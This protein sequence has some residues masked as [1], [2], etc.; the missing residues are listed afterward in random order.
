MRR[1]LNRRQNRDVQQPA[2]DSV[3]LGV[4]TRRTFLSDT[5]KKMIFIM[6]AVWTLSGQ[7]AVAATGD[8]CSQYGADCEVNEDCC[9][10]N[11]HGPTMTCKGPI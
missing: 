9:S 10:L 8:S 11:C 1:I 5:G 6:P 3:T 7:Q 2:E 4:R